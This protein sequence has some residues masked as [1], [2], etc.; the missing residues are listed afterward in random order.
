MARSPVISLIDNNDS[1]TFNVYQYLLGTGAE[2]LVLPCDGLRPDHPELAQCDGIVISPGPGAPSQA[3]AA[4][5]V[6]ARYQGQKPILGICLGHQ[7]IAEHFGA[8]VERARR[9]MHGKVSNITHDGKGVY[10]GLPTRFLVARYH[11][12]IATPE[13]LPGDLQISSQCQAPD[14]HLEIMGLRHHRWPI[15]GIQFHPEAIQSEHGQTLLA[16]FTQSCR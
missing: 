10:A 9:V 1:F 6:L 16:N 15:E 3:R 14:G 11:S 5:A 2:V 13:S 8:R 12:L 7:V 4:R